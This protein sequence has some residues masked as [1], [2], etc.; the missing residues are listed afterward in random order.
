LSFTLDD[1][2]C[3]HGRRR[4]ALAERVLASHYPVGSLAELAGNLGTLSHPG[5]DL[6]HH[7]AE[8]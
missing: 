1:L 4:Y 2:L 6:R 8:R 3:Q 7:G 5:V